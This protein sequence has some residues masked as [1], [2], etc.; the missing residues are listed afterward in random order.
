[1]SKRALLFP[2]QGAQKIG[3]GLDIAAAVPEVAEL[4]AEAEGATGLPLS[5]LLASGPEDALKDTAVSQPAI[6]FA[7]LAALMAFEKTH[8]RV[9]PVAAAGLS[10]GE[11][12]A[13]SAAGALSPREAL[14]LVAVR[15]RFMKEC[16]EAVPGTMASVIGLE[17]SKV[18]QAV[19]AAK[20]A[21]VV[22]AANF[23]SPDQTVVSGE[24]RAVEKA[25][26]LCKAAGAKRA[27]PLKVSGAFHSPLMA[28]AA[29]R[30]APE[31]ER[32]E[33]RPAR[34]PVIA[35]AT[36]G[37]VREPAEIRRALVEQVTAPVLW[38]KSLE[39]M[40]SLGAAEL[41]ELGPGTVL[42]GL[43]GRTVPGIRALSLGT[44]AAIKG[45]APAGG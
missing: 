7:D 6:V 33:I 4:L 15:G 29:E 1:M 32:A 34:Y 37:A 19:A 16:A 44:M 35:N 24:A 3:M 40:R 9:E 36:G 14:R 10:L 2:G 39:T 17:A 26:E 8:G 11:Y 45:Y 30:L 18:V 42:A 41:L 20:S 31:V 21:G 12:A 22:V 28:H 38:T 5:Q 23:N 13:L 43:A 25:C 27:I